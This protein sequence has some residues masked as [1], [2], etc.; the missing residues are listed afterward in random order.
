MNQLWFFCCGFLFCGQKIQ[1]L[2]FLQFSCEK[3]ETN[4][5]RKIA[6]KGTRKLAQRGPA[7][8][9]WIV[10]KSFLGIMQVHVIFIWKWWNH[11]KQNI[12]EEL[13]LHEIP[14]LLHQYACMI[15]I[16]CILGKL[17]MVL[18]NSKV[19]LFVWFCSKNVHA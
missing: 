13:F 17:K 12:I 3:I 1:H 6:S 4:K 5:K 10:L 7:L 14:T 15:S 16:F 11:S 9:H 18:A 8:Y 19:N 2:A